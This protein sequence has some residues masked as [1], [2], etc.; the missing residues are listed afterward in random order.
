MR[1]H[2]FPWLFT[3]MLLLV[4]SAGAE[5][6]AQG[7]FSGS[8]PPVVIGVLPSGRYNAITD[9]AGVLVGHKTLISGTSVRTG[10]TA[11]LPHGSNLFQS[12]VPAAIYAANGFGKL[13]GFTQVKELGNIDSPV[14]L[15]NTLNVAN[16]LNAGITYTRAQEGDESTAR[17]EVVV[18]ETNDGYLNDSRGRHVSETDVLEAMRNATTS[19]AAHGNGGAGTGTV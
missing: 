14:I 10:V 16:A 15:T 8:K 13:A 4:L 6:L 11:V 18:G 5:S 17:V 2:G 3:V 12:K 7:S 1:S 9:V 19:P